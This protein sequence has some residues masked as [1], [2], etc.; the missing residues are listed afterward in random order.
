MDGVAAAPK[1]FLVPSKKTKAT[2][3]TS[4]PL[5]KLT[6]RE[7]VTSTHNSKTHPKLEKTTKTSDF[8]EQLHFA[9]PIDAHYSKKR[10]KSVD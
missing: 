6:E 4:C 9:F 10:V 3:T 7:T 2:S 1:I 8:F 5:I